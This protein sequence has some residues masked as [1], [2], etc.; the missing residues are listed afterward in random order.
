MIHFLF[1][2]S[3]V[4][5]KQSVKL[6]FAARDYDICNDFGETD[7]QTDLFAEI[8]TAFDGGVSI[9]DDIKSDDYV[10]AFFP[11]TRF[12]AR[13]PTLARTD[14][15]QMF[16]K[17]DDK[18][19]LAYSMNIVNEIARNYSILCKMVSVCLE[20][21]LKLIIENPVTPPHFLTQYFPLKPK[22]IH[23]NRA[24][25][26]DYYRKPTQYFFHQLRTGL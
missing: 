24:E 7:I 12:S 17:W 21:G 15:Q 2:Q 18:R 11:C 9:F 3:G 20:R 23:R 5:K 8:N 16:G 4:F 22:I 10:I 6:G 13:V 25:F 19:R 14:M 26:G 1:E